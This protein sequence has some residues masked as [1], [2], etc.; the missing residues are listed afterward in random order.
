VTLFTVKDEAGVPLKLTAVALLKFVPATTTAVPTGPVVGLKPEIVGGDG[1]TVKFAAEVAVPL[2]VVTETF[3]VVVL[4]A[5]VAVIC[6]AL[7]TVKE[8][9]AL[10]LNAT[11][12]APLKLVPVITTLAPTNP[13]AGLKLEIVGAGGSTVKLEAE[14]P[15]PMGV[16]TEIFPVVAPVGTGAVIWVALSTVNVVAVPLKLTAVA[17]VKFVPVIV[18]LA[19]TTPLAGLKLERVGPRFTVK[20]LAEVAVPPGVVTEICPVVEPLATIAVICVALFTAKEDAAMPLNLTLVAPV[21]FVPVMVTV[22]P[23]AP[24]AGLKLEIAGAGGGGLDPAPELVAPPPQ[25][26]SVNISRPVR[27]AAEIRAAPNSLKNLR[28]ARFRP[29]VKQ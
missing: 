15:V 23:K 26:T 2:A 9:A 19:P 1:I 28:V 5:T 17:P 29:P 13:L 8:E 18:M 3:P 10:P 7:F 14:V 16:V 11:A 4:L 22:A 21:K 24:L 20:L 12:V 6:V 27:Q 25:A